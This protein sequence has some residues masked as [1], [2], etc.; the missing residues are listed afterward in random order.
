MK[1][2]CLL[3]LYAVPS[4]PPL[5]LRAVPSSKSTILTWDPPA[6]KDQNGVIIGYLIKYQLISDPSSQMTRP[7]GA[8]TQ[9]SLDNLMT[10]VTYSFTVA[11][12]N[13]N[14]TGPDA[15]MVMFTTIPDVENLRVS[16]CLLYTSPSPRDRQKSRMPSSA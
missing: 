12:I 16:D 3:L 10:G 7:V 9:L 13:S 6:E 8:V 15:T 1:Y 2:H 11:A 5:N 14:G 4:G